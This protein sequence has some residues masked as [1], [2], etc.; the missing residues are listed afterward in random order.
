M[1]RDDYDPCFVSTLVTKENWKQYAEN[2]IDEP[3]AFREYRK[4]CDHI[5]TL[6]G[7]A[8]VKAKN[9]EELQKEITSIYEDRKELVKYARENEPW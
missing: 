7:S 2:H 6:L 3:A 1:N 8:L 5:V 9:F 4:A